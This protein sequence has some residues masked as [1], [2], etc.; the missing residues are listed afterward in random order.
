MRTTAV[1]KTKVALGKIFNRFTIMT[2]LILLQFAYLAV[3]I[4]QLGSYAIW[5]TLSFSIL[6]ALVAVFIIYRNDH[7][8]YKMGWI[9][10][11]CLLPILGVTMYI[12]FGNKRPSRRIKKRVDPVDQAH[13]ED[14]AQ[15]YN[16]GEINN[17]R[18]MKTIE[19]ISQYG[20]YPAWAGTKTGYYASGDEAFPDLLEDLWKAKHFI[21]LE[22]FIIGED[23][24]MWNEILEILRE[25]VQEG[26]D[27]RV[28][29]DDIGSIRSVHYGFA[30][31][32]EK[33]GIKAMAFNPVRPFASLVYNNRDHRKLCVIDGYIAHTGGY[34]LED[35]YINQDLRFG[36]WKDAG[37]RLEGEAVW[38]FTVMFLN[39]WNAFRKTEADYDR[40]GPYVHHPEPFDSDGIVQPYSDTPL[41]DEELGEN[42]YL[43]MISQAQEYVYIFTPYLI[44]DSEI[45]KAMELASKR[46]VDIRVVTPGVPDKRTVYRLTRSYY[47]PLLRAGV[48][49]YEYSPGFIHSKCVLSD[50][51]KGIVGTIN[52]DYRSLFLHF[53]CGTLLLGS[54]ALA[55]LK[56]DCQ[57]TFEC[58]RQIHS[59]SRHGSLLG[60]L[61]DGVLRALSPL[62]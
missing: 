45:L 18:I 20:P 3:A 5:T 32:L 53:E 2:V 29:Y 8:A 44:L 38:N 55:G 27:V 21:F 51:L 13:R 35:A 39:M 26:V 50:D 28:I 57:N 36:H 16:L 41:D 14:L 59:G 46:G 1:G 61:Y 47:P 48:K 4:F 31:R 19:Y 33:E 54:S 34:N 60:V 56:E 15:V 58:C 43:E 24:R 17:S 9:M 11:I 52:F 7:P 6:S 37:L 10:L 40:F 22:Y 23:S 42:V 62:L 49:V 12:F 25:K 30:Q